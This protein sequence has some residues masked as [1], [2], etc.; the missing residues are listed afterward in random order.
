MP[1]PGRARE[2]AG[3]HQGPLWA[4]WGG[5]ASL[6]QPPGSTGGSCGQSVGCTHGL[7]CS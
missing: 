1:R 3:Q 4:G 7:A 2:R 5:A 6:Q